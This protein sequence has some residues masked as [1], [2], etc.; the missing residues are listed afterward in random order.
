MDKNLFEIASRAKLRFETTKG[1]ISVEEL[2]DIPLQGKAVSL[3]ELAK[4]YKKRVAAGQEEDFVAMSS[5]TSG[6]SNAVVELDQIA[7]ELI[8][9]VIDVRVKESRAAEEAVAEEQRKSKI[10]E[11]IAKKKDSALENMSVEELEKL[12]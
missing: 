4:A 12:L 6:N 9:H 2:W 7:F 10:R 8:L 1:L 5:R 11:I 3:N